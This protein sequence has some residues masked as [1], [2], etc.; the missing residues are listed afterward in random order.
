MSHSAGH[1]F[2][3]VLLC[4][5]SLNYHLVNF[6]C[7]CYLQQNTVYCLNQGFPTGELRRHKMCPVKKLFMELKISNLLKTFNQSN[8]IKS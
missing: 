6:L 7:V 3:L 8:V 4:F 5:K 1:I 2:V